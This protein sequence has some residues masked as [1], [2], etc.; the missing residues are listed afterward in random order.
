MSGGSGAHARTDPTSREKATVNTATS[1][2]CGSGGWLGM[3]AIAAKAK[4]WNND[5]AG[6]SRHQATISEQLPATRVVANDLEPD[7]VR[8]GERQGHSGAGGQGGQ[9]HDH[10]HQRP[11]A[12]LKAEAPGV[13]FVAAVDPGEGAEGSEDGQVEAVQ[14]HQGDQRDKDTDG[15]A[16]GHLVVLVAGR[17]G[18]HLGEHLQ[19]WEAPFVRSDCY[20]GGAGIHAPILRPEGR[21]PGILIHSLEPALER[22]RGQD[23]DKSA[24]RTA[25]SDSV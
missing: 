7:G 8:G 24:D 5:P 22:A 10:H 2:A 19:G 23:G 14:E 1:M 21:G 17:H 15:A 6:R 16:D 4:M 3:D 18:E 13:R 20:D 9:Q 12:E 25:R 11:G